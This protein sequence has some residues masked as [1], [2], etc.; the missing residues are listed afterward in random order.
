MQI[1]NHCVLGLANHVRF[2]IGVDRQHMLCSH[3]SDPMLDGSRD[4]A[5]NVEL[6]RN[7]LAGLTHLVAMRTP[8]VVGD[9]S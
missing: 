8:T 1:A 2:V 4:A 3:H 7:A 9:D 5:G 6:R